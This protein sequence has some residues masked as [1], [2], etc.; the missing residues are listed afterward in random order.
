MFECSRFK[1]N[2]CKNLLS[3]QFLHV[4]PRYLFNA[5]VSLNTLESQQSSFTPSATCFHRFAQQHKYICAS[6]HT[7]THTLHQCTTINGLTLHKMCILIS[8]L[9]SHSGYSVFFHCEG[10]TNLQNKPESNLFVFVIDYP[11]T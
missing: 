2:I 1:L 6:R 9:I 3:P 11:C 4:F 8:V 10:P 7:H 5:S